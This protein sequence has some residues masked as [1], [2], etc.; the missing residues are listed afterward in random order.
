ME[1]LVFPTMVVGKP[2]WR[3]TAKQRR[4]ASEAIR[5]ARVKLG[6]QMKISN[7]EQAWDFLKDFEYEDCWEFSIQT[8][9]YGPQ[10]L[11]EVKVHDLANSTDLIEGWGKT[12]EEAFNSCFEKAEEQLTHQGFKRK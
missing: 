11:I 6:T 2:S 7:Y 10:D 8:V 12:T 5:R 3:P 1:Q 4:I 9:Y